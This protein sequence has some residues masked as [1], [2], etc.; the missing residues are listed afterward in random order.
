MIPDRE[1]GGVDGDGYA[2]CSGLLVV[3][4]EATLAGFIE[5]P[6]GIEGERMGRDHHTLHQLLAERH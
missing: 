6:A 3:S 2:S 5:F 1:L 4:S